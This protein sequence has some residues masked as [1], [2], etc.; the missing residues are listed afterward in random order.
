[1]TWPIFREG[2]LGGGTI[3]EKVDVRYHPFSNLEE[4]LS[5]ISMKMRKELVLSTVLINH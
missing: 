4:E 5:A 1:M 3:F 2:R